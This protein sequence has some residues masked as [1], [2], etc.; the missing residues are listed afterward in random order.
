MS[1]ATLTDISRPEARRAVARSRVY[2]T[3]ARLLDYPDAE[4]FEDIRDGTLTRAL[5]A[6]LGDVDPGLAR[7]ANWKALGDCGGEPDDLAVEY[8][9]LFDVG[10]G[11][12][13]CPL[14]GGLYGG[15][16]MKTMEE[17]VRFYNHFGLT[18]C[19]SPREMPDHL[20]TQLEFLHFLAFREG[21]AI[22]KGSD[23]GP[24]RRAQRDFIS[25]HPGR[26]VP[27]LSSRLGKHE[28]LPF[29]REL[30]AR[31][32]AFLTHDQSHLVALEGPAPAGD[33]TWLRQGGLGLV[34]RP[35]ARHTCP[36]S[37]CR[38]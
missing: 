14:Y 12:P 2:E 29:F 31:L 30:V 27:R 32:E 28:A 34:T 24:Y 20:A 6:V 15:T 26:W 3:F 5:R 23:S 22:E 16:R 10:G 37:P 38:S 35:D 33:A 8:T 13:P 9:R 11:G 4:L 1:D 18:L 36:T 21:E 19:E 17:A 25:R 7:V